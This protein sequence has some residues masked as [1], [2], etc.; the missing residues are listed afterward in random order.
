MKV[1][2]AM[3]TAAVLVTVPVKV[4]ENSAVKVLVAGL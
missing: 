4:V 3:W 2:P 1:S